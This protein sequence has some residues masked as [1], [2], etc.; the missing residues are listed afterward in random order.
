MPAILQGTRSDLAKFLRKN[1]REMRL[2]L[3]DRYDDD[4][5]PTHIFSAPTRIFDGSRF[6]DFQIFP[7]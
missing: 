5:T 7:F 6:L 2:K 1:R 4:G 3:F